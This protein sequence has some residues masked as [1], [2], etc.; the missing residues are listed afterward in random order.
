MSERYDPKR[1]GREYQSPVYT[2][3]VCG[4]ETLMQVHP[5]CLSEFV[6]RPHESPAKGMAK[7]C[8]TCPFN[9]RVPAWEPRYYVTI[10]SIKV[11]LGAIQQCHKD[12]GKFCAGM[13]VCVRGGSSRVRSPEQYAARLYETTPQGMSAGDWNRMEASLL[14]EAGGK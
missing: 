10:N 6:R 2:C 11:R 5:R 14:Q 4:G 3:F 12:L 7:L 13:T 9:L 8:A 1:V